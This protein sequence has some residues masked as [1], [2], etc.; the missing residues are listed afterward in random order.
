MGNFAYSKSNGITES[1][2]INDKVAL[3]SVIIKF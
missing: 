1:F 3:K 2:P